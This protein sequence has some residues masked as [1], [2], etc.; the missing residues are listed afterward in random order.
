MKHMTGFGVIEPPGNSEVRTLVRSGFAML[1]TASIAITTLCSMSASAAPGGTPQASITLSNCDAEYCY[2]QDN[3]WTLE[4][5]GVYTATDPAVPN[6]GTVTWT[7]TATKTPGATTF[8]VHGGLTV[9]NSGSAPATIGNIVV[10]L[11]KPNSPKKGSN[12]S[13]VSIAADVADATDGDGATSASIVAAGSQE[14]MATNTAW[15]TSNYAVSGAKGTFS[16]TAGSGLLEFT[17]ASNNTLFS[18]VPQPSIPVGGSITLL[19]DATFQTSVLPPAGTPL[20]VETI[21]TFG[22][23]GARGGSGASASNIDINGNGSLSPDEANVRSVPCRVSM[24][25][26]PIAPEQC[27]DSVIVSDPADQALSV[28]GTVTATNPLGF[29]DSETISATTTFGPIS[30][31]VN[32]GSAGGQVCNTADLNG[33]S[34][35]GTLTVV[36][37]HTPDAFEDITP[38]DGIDNPVNVGNQP[39]YAPYTCCEA[40]SAQAVSCVAVPAEDGGGNPPP[41]FEGA[42]YQASEWGTSKDGTSNNKAAQLR[43]SGFATIYSSGGVVVGGNYHMTFTSAAYVAGYLGGNHTPGAPAAL[44]A[45]LLNPTES[46]SHD[47]GIHVLALRL[48]VDL[49]AGFGALQLYGF[50]TSDKL[51]GTDLTSAQCVALNGQTVSDVLAVMNLALGG[52]LGSHYAGLSIAQLTDLAL[53]LNKSYNNGTNNNAGLGDHLKVVP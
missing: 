42:T 40:A 47:F 21:V 32:G 23:A 46:A 35:G 12:A 28:S 31:D 26:L 25:G 7:L 2:T 1:L 29:F 30:V 8:T 20:R 50:T 3:T 22:N 34:T 4:K 51:D 53:L 39:I 37:G 43:A 5:T 52:D 9:Y 41:P 10:N 44:N 38:E 45:N 33:E 17:D 19:Y 48:N 6:I 15:G 27:N 14:N 24:A 16:E 49:V 11:Q 18:L 13:H 36:I